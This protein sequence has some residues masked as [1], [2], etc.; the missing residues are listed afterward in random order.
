[1]HLFFKRIDKTTLILYFRNSSFTVHLLMR[2]S[3][4]AGVFL[5]KNQAKSAIIFYYDGVL[6]SGAFAYLNH[7]EELP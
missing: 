2:L 6:R 3:W 5:L 1:M 4:A 7:K